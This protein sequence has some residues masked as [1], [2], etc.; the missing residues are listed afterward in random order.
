MNDEQLQAEND[1]LRKEIEAYRQRELAAL[2]EQLAEARASV[3]HYKEEAERNAQVGRQIHLTAQETIQ[4]LRS[5]LQ[6]RDAILPNSR[7]GF[8]VG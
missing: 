2:R 4:E 7:P 5:K 6:A 1:R 3:R 8:K